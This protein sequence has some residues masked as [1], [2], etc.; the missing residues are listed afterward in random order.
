MRF[1][2]LI[3]R[4][5]LAFLKNVVTFLSNPILSLIPELSLTLLKKCLTNLFKVLMK[6]P[7]INKALSAS[8]W[9]FIILHSHLATS[10][11]GG[12]L[13]SS[14]DTL[15]YTFYN[16][17]QVNAFSRAAG[18][19]ADGK[20]ILA[21]EYVT[22]NTATIAVIR[23]TKDGLPDLSFGTNGQVLIPFTNAAVEVSV[24]LIL[25]DGSI[26]LGGKSNNQPLLVKMNADGS[27]ATNFG[28]IGIFSF[29][30]GL[31]G[32]VDLIAVDGK[33]LGCA[34]SGSQICVFKRN[35]NGTEDISFAQAGFSCLDPG[36]QAVLTRMV[37]QSDG[38]IVLT[39]SALNQSQKQDML[40]LRLN[41]DGS[42]DNSFNQSGS[43]L[44]G[45]G[46]ATSDEMA[47]AIRV[48]KDG[49]II[50]AGIL[51][52]G[53][54]DTSFNNTG[55][56]I[57][58]INSASTKDDVRDMIIQ[59]DAKILICGTNQTSGNG[60]NIAMMRLKPDGKLDPNFGGIGKISSR[61]GMRANGEVIM[62][63]PDHKI[64][65]TGYASVNNL[66]RFMA[67]RYNPGIIVSTKEISAQKTLAGIE[68]WPNPVHSG[69]EI[70]II[71][72]FKESEGLLIKLMTL[73]GKTLYQK[74]FNAP[75]LSDQA[76][77]LKLPAGI[78]PETYMLQVD[79]KKYTASKLLLIE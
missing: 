26:V 14:F 71:A 58:N 40:V 75:A 38:K 49:K 34:K 7:I 5:Q 72:D 45:L 55:S 37:L 13:D 60:S 62:V 67:A 17:P 16:F 27:L 41:S 59:A 43:V 32:I 69:D 56:T 74:P 79:S 28:S 6:N 42:P 4:L 25:P 65:V 53:Q 47:T 36:P 15:G 8:L 2:I 73:E 9:I 10:Q 50:V 12:T 35:E 63:Q 18:I 48:Q 19:Q 54:I 66:T 20:I 51:E 23:L 76:L 44:L 57:L 30:N 29:D 61:I 33:L 24:S 1:C 3:I 21:G 22:G 39:G 70:N 46:T 64:V 11:T 31:S 68:V 78:K 52:D 77:K